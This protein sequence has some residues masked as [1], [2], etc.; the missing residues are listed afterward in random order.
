MPHR[1][2]ARMTD[3]YRVGLFKKELRNILGAPWVR[4]YWSKDR[5]HLCLTGWHMGD[6]NIEIAERLLKR[7]RIDI[8]VFRDE[9]GLHRARVTKQNALMALKW[10]NHDIK[11]QRVFDLMPQWEPLFGHLTKDGP[12]SQTY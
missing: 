3:L 5:Q 8:T 12:G 11:L 10:N 2:Y 4:F 1:N 6:E 7:A 9:Y